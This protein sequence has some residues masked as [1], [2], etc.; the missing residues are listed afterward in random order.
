M[1]KQKLF[2]QAVQYI[3]EYLE[4]DISH[5]TLESRVAAISGLDSLKLFESMLY[6]EEQFGVDFDESVMEHIDTMNDLVNYIET[7]LASKQIS[8]E[9][10]KESDNKKKD[11]VTND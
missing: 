11:I 2:S 4:T 10:S 3:G 1:E 9:T 7:R 8:D 6:L 5:V